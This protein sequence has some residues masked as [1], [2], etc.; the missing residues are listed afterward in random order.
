MPDAPAGFPAL[1]AV[2]GAD[3]SARV[4]PTEANALLQRT[5]TAA[6]AVGI[7][8]YDAGLIMQ[9]WFTVNDWVPGLLLPLQHKRARQALAGRGR[10]T[11]AAAAAA[12]HI[13]NAGW[14][15]GLLLVL[16]DE[17]LI[18]I[19]R[20]TGAVYQVVISGI[21]DN[22]QLHTLLA[23]TLIGD[24]S[25]GL[26]PGQRP[27]PTWVAAATDGA[28]TPPSR[29]RGQF[30]LVAGTGEPIPNGGRPADIP[31]AAGR[32]I[33][34]LDLPPYQRAWTIGR[35]YPL[36]TPEIQ[37]QRVLPPDES[38][39]WISRIAPAMPIS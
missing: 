18:V 3:F 15:L 1:A 37:L 16:D 33:V 39:A 38:A 28:M 10:L 9:S 35:T 8:A 36:M 12:D 20:A 26:I 34:I 6:V 21:G 23:A 25:A 31:A 4:E 30:N 19:H 22:F 24:P 27:D 2:M 11:D 29:I 32:R 5:Q 13:P 7:D 17:R 14:L